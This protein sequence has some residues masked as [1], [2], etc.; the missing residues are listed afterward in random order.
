[1][2][3][4]YGESTKSEDTTIISSGVKIEG[5]VRTN[6]NIR[7][8]GEIQG[9]IISEN[10]ITVGE[11][12]KVNGK[13][14]ALTISV[15]GFVTGTIEAKEKFN[16]TSRGKINGDVITKSLIVEDGGVLN[17]NCKMAGSESSTQY[18]VVSKQE[19]AAN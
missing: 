9:D 12:G 2:K 5:T 14:N 15:G 10:Y 8:D 11:S 13:I 17:G 3:S 16:L 4:I 1:M 7:V 19:T 18:T 6:G